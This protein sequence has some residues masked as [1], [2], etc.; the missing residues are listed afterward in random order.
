MH[1]NRVRLKHLASLSLC[2]G[3]AAAA[4]CAGSASEAPRPIA[5]QQQPLLGQDGSLIYNGTDAINRYAA[6][7][8]DI[9]AG[10]TSITV[11]NATTLNVTAGDLLMIIQMQGATIDVTDTAVYG[12][13]TNLNNAGRYEFA[14]VVS[15][16]S[17]TI[18]V[19]A[20]KACGAA[21]A[22]GGLKNSYT[23]AGK[24]QAVRVPQYVSFTVPVGKTLTAQAW[25]GS[26]GG[27]LAYSAL[28]STI[29][30]TI[31]MT[32]TGFR[33]GTVKTTAN[34]APTTAFVATTL[35][36]GAEK[37]ESIAGSV[38]DYAANKGQYG[39]GAPANGGGGGN[40]HN[41]GGG[42]GAN[43]DNGVAWT[44]IGNMNATVNKLDAWKLDPEYIK[45]TKLTTSS[46]GG[47][48]G[49][50]CS[51]SVLDPTV[52]G[53]GTNTWGCGNRTDAGGY[54]GHPV[55][56][57]VNTRLFLGGGGGAGDD[58][59]GNGG[60]G[61]VGGGIIFI[62]SNL[63]TST[64]AAAGGGIGVI[65]SNGGSGGAAG[66]NLL[67]TSDAPGGGG[68]G[69][70]I[71]LAASGALVGVKVAANGGAGGD[72]SPTPIS[73]GEGEGAGGGG[74]G[75]YIALVGGAAQSSVASGALAG[76]TSQLILVKMPTNGG[77]D[78]ATGKITSL[79]SYGNLTAKPICA[80][81]DIAVTI[82]DNLLGTAP[83]SGGTVI[84]TVTITN[85]GPNTAAGIKVTDVLSTGSTGA[86]WTCTSQAAGLCPM[87]AGTGSIATNVL[88]LPAGASVVYKVTVP[89]PT[90][91]N[92]SLSYTVTASPPLDITDP[93]LVNNSATDTSVGGTPPQAD[94][95]LTIT[96][97][98]TTSQPGAEVTYTLQVTNNGPATVPTATVV[99]TVPPGATV[100]QPAQGTGW[101][102]LNSGDTFTCT[103]T[104][105]LAPGSAAPITVKLNTPLAGTPGAANPAVNGIVG[106]QGVADPNVTNNFASVDSSGV[107][108][109]AADLAVTIT[110]SPDAAMAGDEVTYTIQATDNG[111]G[112]VYNAVVNF[113]V[114]PSAIV[115]M[116]AAGQGWACQRNGN[117]FTC[118][119]SVIDMGAAPPIVAKI[120]TP[121]AG[122]G[123]GSGVVAAV[124]SA[125][126]NNDP[127]LANNTA[128]V[129]AGTTTAT[130]S[131]LAVTLT[132]TNDS[133]TQGQTTYTLQAT[134]K[135]PDAVNGV[136]VTL[137]VP[138]GY[139]IVQ[140]AQGSG[141]TCSFDGS[142]FLCTVQTAPVGD[143]PPITLIL[144][145][146]AGTSAGVVT[147][148][149]AAA[150]NT[151]PVS[152][153]N[154]ATANANGTGTGDGFNK[155]AGG[156]LGCTISGRSASAVPFF[157]FLA[158]GLL[159]GLSASARRRRVSVRA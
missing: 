58:D 143:L 2:F 72:H 140:P 125:P 93:N 63:I 131:D 158:A 16:T 3:L 157:G 4:G 141:W 138:A 92:P 89:V 77:T 65:K 20:G 103:S 60:S 87:A 134:N 61:G 8:A 76:V 137:S 90:T 62:N 81:A 121:V 54:G 37:G 108:M 68:G 5:E 109:T 82:T 27:V 21:G 86:T 98:P 111:P 150:N 126:Q 51:T 48:G 117:M 34:T 80:P 49:Y 120:I 55:A 84:Y 99:F 66:K 155:L 28:I 26:T 148:T 46:G 10:A 30:G 78:G 91:A 35:D 53:P 73:P 32:A 88:S 31:D 23:V 6:V 64:G 146:S 33:G 154:V 43:G 39:R 75:G 106:A 96:R 12:T 38:T 9:A 56:A 156:G 130:G 101:T 70:T 159:V 40:G 17:N 41:G 142:T 74:G 19:D 151:D 133:P 114:P 118:I 25:N 144:T 127:N 135:G 52:V 83:Q 94:L 128:V 18:Q 145:S 69:G 112:S 59:N 13:V 122:A 57:D 15:V 147:G 36:Q 115:T 24:V 67:I 132:K 153:N 104:A 45:A 102:C 42:G 7:T 152:A 123:G 119:R 11:A 149:I 14:S 95:A 29:D 50:G 22:T 107:M 105:P 1:R 129:D 85:N 97:D 47:R 44:G 71:V 136:A 100:T 124:V 79:G 139:Q 113:S 116:P 110:K